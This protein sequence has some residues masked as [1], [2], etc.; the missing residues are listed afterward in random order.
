MMLNMLDT[1]KHDHQ[2]TRNW[3]IT[4]ILKQRNRGL[5]FTINFQTFKLYT[6]CN[7]SK[8]PIALCGSALKHI[9]YIL[10]YRCVNHYSEF[11]PFITVCLS[12]LPVSFS[13]HNS[14]IRSYRIWTKCFKVK[15]KPYLFKGAWVAQLLTV[16]LWLKSWSQRSG[17]ELQI[18]LP[19]Q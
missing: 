12:A 9:N 3:D 10:T 11:E 7:H 6:I 15:P 14:Y 4:E 17:T 5:L 1:E 8:T 2:N 16:F 13:G 18:R 19:V